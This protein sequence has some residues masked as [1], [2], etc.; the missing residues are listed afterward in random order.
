[1]CPTV[2]FDIIDCVGLHSKDIGWYPRQ[3]ELIKD[4]LYDFMI[5]KEL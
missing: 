5:E 3:D 1:M 2:G 4:L